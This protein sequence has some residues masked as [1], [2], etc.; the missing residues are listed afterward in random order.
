MKIR[1]KEG[2]FMSYYKG[3]NAKNCLFLYDYGNKKRGEW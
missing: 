3:W 2:I 1:Q